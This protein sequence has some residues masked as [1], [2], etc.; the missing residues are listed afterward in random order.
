MAAVTIINTD[1]AF[2]SLPAFQNLIKGL[3]SN[4]VSIDTPVGQAIDPTILC[5]GL[6]EMVLLYPPTEEETFNAEI[7][8]Y[9]KETLRFGGLVSYPKVVELLVGSPIYNEALVSDPDA[10]A[11][12]SDRLEEV[13]DSLDDWID[14]WCRVANKIQFVY[15]DKK[16][17]IDVM[18]SFKPKRNFTLNG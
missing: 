5:T 4:T 10:M 14:N 6:M 1:L 7:I 9:I 3:D 16:K 8:G 11:M 12:Q 15:G 17:V 2:T 13:Q 18:Q